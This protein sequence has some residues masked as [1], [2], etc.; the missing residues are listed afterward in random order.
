MKLG[1]PLQIAKKSLKGA[2]RSLCALSHPF[3]W[4]RV[5][6]NARASRKAV[7]DS[8]S[9]FGECLGRP[10]NDKKA[11]WAI[12]PKLQNWDCRRK[13]SVMPRGYNPRKAAQV[14]A[15]LVQGRGGRADIIDVVK[16]AYLADRSFLNKYDRP[17]LFDELYCLDHGPVD[18]VTYDSIKR[19]G[20]IEEPWSTYLLP[21]DGHNIAT[22]RA[23]RPDDFD[24]L[25]AAE[26]HTLQEILERFANIRD[27]NLVQWIHD[28]CGEWSHPLGSSTFLA[29]GDVFKALGKDDPD[30]R[31]RHVAEL[32]NIAHSL[33]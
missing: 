2:P 11:G 1:H 27:F 5:R 30:E 19:N 23:F 29:Y 33:R 13:A 7:E 22:V 6:A 18:S 17:I 9:K 21:R 10:E 25:S 26:E 28:N 15:F 3:V 12:V 31:D 14:I 32:S 8:L 24:E 16:L 20:I 4:C